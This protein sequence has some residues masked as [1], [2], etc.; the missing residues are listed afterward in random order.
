MVGDRAGLVDRLA[1]HVDDAAERLVADRHRDRRAGIGDVLAAHQAFGGV[2]RDGAHGRLAEMLRDFEHQAVA[3]V[4]GLERVQ[5]RR[6]VTVELHVDDGADDLG[7]LSDGV[8]L[9]RGHCLPL[10]KSDHSASAPEMIS[11]SS[12]VIIAWRVRL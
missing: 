1:D 4:L 5:D 9:G 3:L 11:I 8:G 7:D 10:A 12:L 2:H 6:Q